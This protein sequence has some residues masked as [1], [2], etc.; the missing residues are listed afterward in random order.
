MPTMTEQQKEEILDPY[1]LPEAGADTL[2]GVK[3]AENVAESSATTV[4]SL[5]ETVNDLL[6]ALKA[7]GIMAADEEV[8]QAET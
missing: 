4:A 3:Q 7:A 2:G 6:S 1:V 5:K 8:E